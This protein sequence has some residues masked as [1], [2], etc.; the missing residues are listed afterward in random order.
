MTTDRIFNLFSGL[1]QPATH[2]GEQVLSLAPKSLFVPLPDWQAGNLVSGRIAERS[3]AD[4]HVGDAVLDL[5]PDSQGPADP[6]R[7]PVFTR[8]FTVAAIGSSHR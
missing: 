5:R 3:V 1:A 8:P 7:S 2:P 4:A 6:A